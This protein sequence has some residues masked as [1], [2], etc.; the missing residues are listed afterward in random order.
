M[1]GDVDTVHIGIEYPSLSPF[2]MQWILYF[3][4]IEYPMA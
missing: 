1:D 3:M 2:K 4:Q